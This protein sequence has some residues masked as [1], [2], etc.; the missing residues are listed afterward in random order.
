MQ[1]FIST[2][3]APM[4]G[5]N[6]AKAFKAVWRRAL[7]DDAEIPAL[8]ASGLRYGAVIATATNDPDAQG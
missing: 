2:G 8:T 6:A 1:L 5:S 7:G 4:D 3:G